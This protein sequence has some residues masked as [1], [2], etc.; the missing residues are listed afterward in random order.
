EWLLRIERLSLPFLRLKCTVWLISSELP[1]RASE[2]RA[3][4][5]FLR[6]PRCKSR[7]T[8]KGA[9]SRPLEGDNC[10]AAFCQPGHH[11]PAGSPV[12]AHDGSAFGR[13]AQNGCDERADLL[14][15]EE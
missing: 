5:A 14:L 3:Q 9:P 6:E 2:R 11:F 15:A 7:T 1:A 12:V 4:A 10:G 13:Q 8:E